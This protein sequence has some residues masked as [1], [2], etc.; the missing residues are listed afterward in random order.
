MYRCI[1]IPIYIYVYTYTPLRIDTSSA[2]NLYTE[3]LSSSL[4]CHHHA[5]MDIHFRF[6]KP[7]ICEINDW[8]QKPVGFYSHMHVCTHI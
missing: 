6:L 8:N 7:I 4:Q 3:V 1:Y 5:S 2:T